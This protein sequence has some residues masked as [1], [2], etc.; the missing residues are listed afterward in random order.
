MKT[1]R[2]ILA[3]LTLAFVFAPH[4]LRTASAA[5]K[6]NYGA[7]LLSPKAGAVLLPGQVVRVEWMAVFPDVDLTLC[8]TE[9]LLSIDGGTTFTYI[10]SQRDP[11]V[12][13]F[14]WTVPR[15]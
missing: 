6:K 8:E 9:I 2:I 10:T 1:Q 11:S 14:N 13:Y 7:K 12:Q 3:L 4:S 5:H 15:T